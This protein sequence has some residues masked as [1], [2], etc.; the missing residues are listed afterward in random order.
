MQIYSYFS[1][2]NNEPVTGSLFVVLV[3]DALK[4]RAAAVFNVNT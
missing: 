1:T 3:E 4:Y 2:T